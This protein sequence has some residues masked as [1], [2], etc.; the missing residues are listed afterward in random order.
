MSVNET[1][2]SSGGGGQWLAEADLKGK[3]H[4]VTISKTEIVETES[5]NDEGVK[6][7]VNKIQLS[8]EGRDKQLLLNK[9]NANIIKDK[10][11]DEETDWLGHE[12]IMYPTT[13]PF[14][15]VITPC[16]RVRFEEEMADGDDTDF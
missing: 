6:R 14:K 3:A 10:L 11:G 13:T 4:K 1:Y 16:I 9:T 7:M 8:F 15:G 2:K 5:E 12:I